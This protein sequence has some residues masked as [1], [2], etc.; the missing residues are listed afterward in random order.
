MS[1]NVPPHLKD[2]IVN[3]ITERYARLKDRVSPDPYS[4]IMTD[5]QLRE[6]YNNLPM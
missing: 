5:A 6:V 4:G 3:P 2:Q 1:E